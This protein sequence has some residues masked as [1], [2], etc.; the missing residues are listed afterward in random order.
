[1]P[2]IRWFPSRTSTATELMQALLNGPRPWMREALA[3]DFP[4]GTKLSLN[5]VTITEGVANVDF[6]DE[7]LGADAQ[8]LR[9]IQAQ[10]KATLLQIPSVERVRI[11]VNR[12]DL[13][14][15]EIQVPMPQVYASA[16]VTLDSDG[17]FQSGKTSAVYTPSSSASMLSGA[18]E[19][20]L[21]ATS[22]KLGFVT[23]LGLY[24]VNLL[25][26]DKS[27]TLVDPRSGLLAPSWD[28][29]GFMWSVGS[30]QSS[31]WRVFD[32]F[33]NAKRIDTAVL[34]GSATTVFGVSPDGARIAA[35]HTGDKR[36]IWLYPILRDNAGLPYK[37]GNGVP[38]VNTF[39][40]A[41]A[42]SWADAG[43]IAALVAD[44]SGAVRP[45]VMTIGGT[46]RVYTAVPGARQIVANLNGPF[47]F[48]LK[49]DGTL[50]QSR[51]S[52]WSEVQLAVRTMHFAGH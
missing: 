15:D 48:V 37:L 4:A 9:H 36:G 31:T 29:R 44:S 12:N 50:L 42:M 52:V 51:S 16:P 25:A 10:V 40:D 1:V 5:S 18:R 3:W 32:A 22:K 21:D 2:D 45:T 43:H 34:A 20:A 6:S 26:I 30:A 19:F 24:Q 46:T 14:I 23:E 39:G 49:D 33:G 11:T 35:L 13:G 28:N 27:P 38:L 47:L 41:F 7:L 17:L 8:A